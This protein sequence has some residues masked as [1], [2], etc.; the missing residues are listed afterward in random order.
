MKPEIDLIETEAKAKLG[1]DA[2]PIE[3]LRF[4]S[5][6]GITR[7]QQQ[8]EGS[9]GVGKWWYDVPLVEV[10]ALAPRL[11]AAKGDRQ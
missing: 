3:L 9:N 6:N 5:A 2:H 11:G 1:L 7:L 8:W 10:A 4:L